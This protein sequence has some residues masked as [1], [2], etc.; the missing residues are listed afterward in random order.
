MTLE[1]LYNMTFN[2]IRATVTR[3]DYMEQSKAWATV[4]SAVQGRLQRQISIDED[5]ERVFGRDALMSD[6]VLFCNP[7]IDIL[8]GDRIVYS[9]RSFEVKGF[10][11]DVNQMG[12]F[13]RVEILEIV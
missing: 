3:G 9:T 8:S 13:Q 2:I 11:D 4:D 12:V 5:E 10:D 1:H 6:Y 7:D